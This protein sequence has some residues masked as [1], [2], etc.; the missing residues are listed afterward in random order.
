MSKYFS[1][2]VEN[3]RAHYAKMSDEAVAEK[4]S[5][6]GFI[7][8]ISVEDRTYYVN[9][10][11]DGL[12]QLVMMEI[13]PGIHCT[14][15]S[16]SL[17]GDYVLKINE[18]FK[19]CAI[20]IEGNGTLYIKAEQRF[21][22]GPVSTYSFHVME[23]ECIKILDAFEKVL[24]KLAG[25]RLITPEEA[26]VEKVYDEHMKKIFNALRDKLLNDDHDEDDDLNEKIKK[27]LE[28]ELEKELEEEIAAEF[29]KIFGKAENESDE[30][31]SK[32]KKPRRNRFLPRRKRHGGDES[33]LPEKND[34]ESIV[35][36]DSEED[37]N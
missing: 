10:R 1:E 35:S 24:D 23:M 28:E 3:A 21:D 5:G 25:L 22:D 15:E 20:H 34:F 31:E 9:T 29:D 33:A 17:V 19:S 27:E 11:I 7:A 13:A 37:E 8:F 2:T 14:P 12:A 30:D 18:S 4:F 36:A 32:E 6:N 26:D 16:R